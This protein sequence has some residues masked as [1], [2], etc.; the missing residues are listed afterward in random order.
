MLEKLFRQIKNNTEYTYHVYYTGDGFVLA[1]A[2]SPRDRQ[3][4]SAGY[5]FVGAFNAKITFMDFVS[6]CESVRVAA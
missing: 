2:N 4:E 6:E 5:E 3:Y 1:P